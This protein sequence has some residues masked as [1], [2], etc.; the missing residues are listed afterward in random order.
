MSDNRRKHMVYFSLIDEPTFGGIPKMQFFLEL[1]LGMLVV[2]IF[3]LSLMSALLVGVIYFGIHRLLKQAY[4]E[5]PMQ[6]EFLIMALIDSQNYYPSAPD[7]N[8][9]QSGSNK[10]I[11]T[12]L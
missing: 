5:D 4:K 8:S 9:D 3:R 1:A 7:I 12:N 2:N 6:V 11:P 10:S